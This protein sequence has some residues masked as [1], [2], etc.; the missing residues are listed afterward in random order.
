[1]LRWWHGTEE[2]RMS[3]RG[4]PAPSRVRRRSGPVR[5]R[6]PRFDSTL[7]LV[8]HGYRFVARECDRLGVDAFRTRL[9]GHPVTC[10]RGHDAARLFYDDARFERRDVLPPRILDT[11]TGRGTVQTLDGDAHHHRKG[12]LLDVLDRDGVDSLVEE[13]RGAWHHHA[14][15]D[16]VVL[17]DEAAVVLCE[18]VSRWTGVVEAG[19]HHAELADRLVDLFDGAGAVGP[20]HWRARRSRRLL[21]HWAA[22]LV[23]DVRRGSRPVDPARPLAVIA[24]HRDPEGELLT[25]RVAGAE[26][27]NL[28]RPTVAVSHWIAWLAVVLHQH[29]RWAGTN[30]DVTISAV[31][32]ELRRH[33]PFFP[34][35]LA[36]ARRDA[37]VDGVRIPEGSLALLDLYATTHHPDLW[38]DP[39]R[40][41][42]DR[43]LAQA[44]HPDDLVPQGGGDPRTG[45][46]CAGEPAAV[47][48]LE[49]ATRLLARQPWHLPAQELRATPRRIPARPRS[50]T[51]IRFDE[52]TAPARP[53]ASPRR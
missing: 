23:R 32:D 51:V 18:A 14:W 28:L 38:D 27:L 34:A 44:A 12:V 16:E 8:R 35:A 52:P 6:K 37:V 13:F 48:L 10:I 7:A 20:R 26:L 36:R 40:F 1:M 9:L 21:D 42:P 31:V 33:A 15:Q 47:A 22:T 41:R 39:H 3:G 46:R 17:F 30:D 25:D 45:H 49:E 11:L 24:T 50:G 29:P 4:R 43:F 53:P 2:E 5:R 19:A